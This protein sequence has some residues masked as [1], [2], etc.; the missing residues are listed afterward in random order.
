VAVVPYK[1]KEIMFPLNDDLIVEIDEENGTLKV[2]LPEGLI[3]LYLE[4]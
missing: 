1:F 3:D 2:D 4:S